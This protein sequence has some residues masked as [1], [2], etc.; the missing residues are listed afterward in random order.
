MTDKVLPFIH[1]DFTLRRRVE[2]ACQEYE[3]EMAVKGAWM[4]RLQDQIGCFSEEEWDAF[5]NGCDEI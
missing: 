3:K 4:Y 1:T 5:L 2:R